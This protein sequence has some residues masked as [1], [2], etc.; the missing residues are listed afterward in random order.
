MTITVTLDADG[1]VCVDPLVKV[2]QR[3]GTTAHTVTWRRG[4]DQDF[5]FVAAHIDGGGDVFSQKSNNGGVLVY[6]DS[7]AKD[8]GKIDYPYTVTVKTPDGK[9][10][11]G[12]KPGPK[13]E[14]GRAVI[15]N[16]A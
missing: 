5:E 8:S 4:K 12:P 2:K 10:H 11:T 7:I 15:R 1:A 6:S 3:D 14:G 13:L 16:E 9:T